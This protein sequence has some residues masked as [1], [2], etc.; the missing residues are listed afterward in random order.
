MWNVSLR[1]KY[2]C[3]R[4][5]CIM[6]ISVTEKVWESESCTD[7]SETEEAPPKAPLK[8]AAPQKE[9][10]WSVFWSG[11]FLVLCNCV[12]DESTLKFCKLVKYT[13]SASCKFMILAKD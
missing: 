3:R 8:E 5:N 10:V 7:Q 2:K 12:F 1:G 11:I 13:G 4:M 6:F 9:K